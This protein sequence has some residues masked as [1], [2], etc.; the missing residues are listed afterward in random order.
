[1]RASCMR[2]FAMGLALLLHSQVLLAQGLPT[3][4]PEDVGMSSER[5]ARLT[6]V[7]RDYVA[8]E[9]L[10]G[11]VVLIARQG[12]VPYFEAFGESDRE[13]RAPMKGD[14]L[15]RIASQTKALVSVAVMM[16]QEEGR[17]LI[18]DPVRKH[19]PEFV[20]TT[21][22]VR[23]AEGDGYDVVDAS[24]PI[25]LRDLL[26]H[27]AGI[28]YGSGVATDRWEAAGIQGWYFADR[29]EPIGETVARMPALPFDAQPG[30]R[31]VYGYATDILGVVVERVS[32]MP[33]DAFLRSRIFEPLG[34]DDTAFYVGADDADRLAT[35]YSATQTGLARAPSPGGMVGQGAYLEGPRRSFSGGAGLVSTAADY[36][37]FLQMLLNG[38]ELD[39]V[40]ILAPST[41]ALMTADHIGERFPT[42]GSGFGLGF[43]VTTDVGRRAQPGSIGTFGWG[44]A[45]HSTYWVDP[46]EEL[47]VV[48]MTQ[49]IPAG[50]LD[51]HGRLRALVYQAIV[52]APAGDVR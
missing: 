38:G 35:V 24:R 2:A 32:G 17:L 48:Y 18:S 19:L 3:A 52:E 28:G 5:L 43:E 15:F 33:L 13:A 20:Q 12:R 46:G 23:R 29:D 47:V 50:G 42:A 40:R 8:D 7:M 21:V 44:G 4:R 37:R 49:L 25:T 10:A 36:A 45:Y 14:A 30:E 39:G 6:A 41:V 16:L 26:T 22:A 11:A 9:R 51:D 27:T 34:M 31:F 1:M